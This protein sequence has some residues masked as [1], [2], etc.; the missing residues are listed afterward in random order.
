MISQI[1]RTFKQ[2][3]HALALLAYTADTETLPGQTRS[4]QDGNSSKDN[5]P[6]KANTTNTELKIE[7]ESRL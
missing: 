5:I 7:E 6:T 3:A 2:K 4:R 1:S